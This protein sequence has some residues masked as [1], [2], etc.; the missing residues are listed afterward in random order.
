MPINRYEWNAITLTQ[1]IYLHDVSL[2]VPI[3]QMLWDPPTPPDCHLSPSF[4][5]SLILTH[6]QGNRGLGDQEIRGLAKAREDNPKLIIA[7]K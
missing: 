4:G 5:T 1:A 7:F 6:R 2:S 3:Y